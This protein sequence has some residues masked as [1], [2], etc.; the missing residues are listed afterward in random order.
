MTF[1]NMIN[2][3]NS[4]G[5]NTAALT[6]I[7]RSITK[8]ASDTFPKMTAIG[9][10]AFANCEALTEITSDTVLTVGE[11]AFHYCSLLATVNLSAATTVETQAFEYCKKLTTVN[12]PLVTTV[13]FGA[14][15][16]CTSLTA[17]TL[18]KAATLQ[19]RVFYECT[20]LVTINLPAVKTI[21]S[22]IFGTY[23]SNTPTNAVLTIG[24][25][26]S[27][28]D[29][30]AFGGFIGTII[31]DRAANAISGSPWGSTGSDIQWTGTN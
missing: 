17:I 3:G 24:K 20:S 11:T 7:D 27:T 28:I 21:G 12:L 22:M 14:F 8:V 10:Y 16:G 31:I 19:G 4:G 9:T 23:S 15:Y 2:G 13:K 26:V 25:T 6:L 18:P 1:F 5:G 30:D 29:S